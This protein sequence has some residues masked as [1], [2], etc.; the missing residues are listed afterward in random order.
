MI[1][2]DSVAGP[3]DDFWY[4]DQ[5][6]VVQHQV[7]SLSPGE[8]SEFQRHCLL[9][10]SKSQERMAYVLGGIDTTASARVLLQLCKRPE[11]DTVLTAREAVRSLSFDSV[12]Q[13]ALEL[14][15]SVPGSST[16]ETLDWI[17][18]ESTK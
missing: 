9:L 4:D 3:S 7:E 13:A 15:P 14:W 12:R 18:G 6:L 1:D 17:E 11:R 5:C 8:W 10:P 2:F 16:N